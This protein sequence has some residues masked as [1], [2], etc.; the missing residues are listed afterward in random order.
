LIGAKIEKFERRSGISEKLARPRLEAL[1]TVLT[2][3]QVM[4][5]SFEQNCNF[6]K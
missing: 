3:V 6:T 2:G 5:F 4:L 1:T